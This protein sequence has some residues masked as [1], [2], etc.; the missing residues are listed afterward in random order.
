MALVAVEPLT[1]FVKAMV[2]GADYR[3]KTDDMESD[4]QVD[5][6]RK[7]RLAQIAVMIAARLAVRRHWLKSHF[8]SLDR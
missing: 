4:L 6:S 3:K 5:A 1:G 2:G 8:R 7:Q